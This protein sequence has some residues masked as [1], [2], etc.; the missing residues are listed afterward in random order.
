MPIDTNTAH[1]YL[2]TFDF[3]R[4]FIEELGWN[5][6]A[7]RFPPFINDGLTFTFTPIAEQGGMVVMLCN[8]SDGNIPAL[9]MRQKIDKEMT[10][11]AAEHIIIFVDG[12]K[13]SS[14]W[15]WVKQEPG[16][17]PRPRS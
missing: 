14:L 10:K 13:T 12:S 8:S 15:W 4:M 11:L 2:R 5:N 9:G 3:K 1:S 6:S 17:P 16:K 7:N